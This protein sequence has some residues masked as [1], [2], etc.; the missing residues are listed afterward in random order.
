V[1]CP[2]C[3]AEISEARKFCGECGSPI[4][5]SGEPAESHTM[6]MES[7]RSGLAT[8]AI[9][10]HR[11]QIIEEL[12]EGGMGKVY[13]VLDTVIDTRIALKLI[14]PGVADDQK[15][16]ERFRNEL[17][18]ARDITHKN[19]C[20]MYHLGKFEDNHYITMEYVDGEDLKDTIKRVG[21]VGER[22]AIA[23]TKQVCA[24]LAEAHRMGIIHR[25]LKPNNIMIDKDG[26]AKI[27]DFGIAR[28]IE[29]KGITGEGIMIGTPEYM[30]PE[31]A[32]AKDVDKRSDIYSLGIV[33]YE[34]VTGELPFSGE[35][36]LSIAM[37]Q[38]REQPEN[39]R[40]LNS[41]ISEEMVAL[42]LKCL[43]KDRRE[44]FQSAD[45]LLAELTEIEKDIHTASRKV[46]R[47]KAK[48]PKDVSASST[49]RKMV[50][51]V[52]VILALIAAGLILWRPWSK[53]DILPTAP[54]SASIAVLPFEDLS[55]QKDQEYVCDGMTDQLITNLTKIPG[56]KVIARASVMQFKNVKKDIGQISHVLGVKYILDGT[57]RK[58]GN[59]L[60]VSASLIDANEGVNIWANDY[61]REWADI[62]AIQYD[63]SK[64]I[65]DALEITLTDKTADAI[66]ASYPRNPE[67]Y[68]Y[69]LQARHY[70]TNI[71]VLTKNEEDFEHALALAE[72]AVELDPDSAYGYLCLAFLY[73]NHW[74]V[75]SRSEDFE[76]EKVLI[77]KA[78]A[79]NPGLA[80]VNAALGLT[81]VRE[82]KYD[83]AFS[84]FKAALVINPD[85][86]EILHLTGMFYQYLGLYHL[87][88]EFLS[89]ALEF[90]PLNFYSLIV[91][92]RAMLAVGEFDR[93]LMD[94]D[95]SDQVMPDNMYNLDT[96][97][98]VLVLQK[99][100]EKAGEVLNR[101][102]SISKEDSFYDPLTLALYLA[103]IGERDKALEKGRYG[104]VFAFLGMKDEAIDAIERSIRNKTEFAST[105]YSYLPLIKL[106]VY[107]SIRDDP[108]F[109]EIVRKEKEKYKV[110]RKKYAL[111]F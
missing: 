42:I 13:K 49:L 90:D 82:K 91:R 19:V 37:K 88:M 34:L 95:K 48:T 84:Y 29:A 20:R 69:Y 51:A 4:G 74:L 97:A 14:K 70:V 89:K 45:E 5:L 8:G 2:K 106:G 103:G 108:R 55:P 6:T 63:V 38:V 67:A 44:R 71:Y 92:G 99:E 109:R 96:M 15:T 75:T 102:E 33:L 7:S 101:I 78:Y 40:T 21:P 35:N 100:Y 47:P 58:S 23:I 1:K 53:Q 104:L 65:A 85:A 86:W 111:T 110:K 76:K 3:Q 43:E 30:S 11:Y 68:D 79:L 87:S 93:A 46:A 28:S 105:F 26:N 41:Q 24:G 98:L 80:E 73:E 94:I 27:M 54:S 31:Q 61:R 72:K 9:F 32:E 39:P 25:D 18:T 16:L 60:S 10:A 17:K 12:G 59:R 52:V 62:I 57:I 107:D 66:Q 56:L 77:E 22:K 64:S 50:V 83:E 36:P 81:R